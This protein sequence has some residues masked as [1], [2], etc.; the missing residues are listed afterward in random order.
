MKQKL[1]VFLSRWTSRKL[2][3]FLTSTA[4]ALFGKLSSSDWVDVAMIYIGSQA[5]VDIATQLKENLK[6]KKYNTEV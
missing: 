6:S 4:L 1:D 5:V 2:M 3:V